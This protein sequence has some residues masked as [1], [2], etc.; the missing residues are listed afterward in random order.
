MRQTPRRFGTAM[1][2]LA[3]TLLAAVPA[4]AATPRPAASDWA[5]DG[6]D[7]GHDAYNP[8]EYRITA[9]TV[10]RL[11]QRWSIATTGGAV[12]QQAPIVAGTQL[13]LTD[14]AGIGAY[15]ATTGV[16]DWQFPLPKTDNPQAPALATDGAAL[17]AYLRTG[18]LVSL[19][20][21]TGSVRWRTPVPSRAPAGKLLLDRGV[22]VAGGNDGENLGA[23]A[24]EAATGK[25]LWHRLGLDPQWP[26]ADGKMLL[27]RPYRGGLQAVDFATGRVAWETDR[28]WFGYAAD[29]TGRFFL[30]GQDNDLLKVRADSGRVVWQA[31]GLSG[32]PAV[33]NDRVYLG[34]EDQPEMVVAVDLY[35]GEERWRLAAGLLPI[36]AGGLLWTSH[37][38]PDQGWQLEALDPVTGVPFDLP[39]AVHNAGGPD[40]TV[41]TH[42][43][44]YTTDG[45]TLRAFTVPGSPEAL[46]APSRS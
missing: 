30:V 40:R 16:A 5:Q 35:T 39:A 42:G 33:D 17:I 2:A 43:W 36:V 8:D 29:P 27:S 25:P 38:S 12:Q 10:N 44:L 15:N 32:A 34:V 7:A 45:A 4:A 46:R 37:S 31:A 26:V 14:S 6:H 41:V 11:V 20:T 18:E 9:G 3:A 23:W 13:F 21:A 1:A 28:D 22:V 24:F 19:D